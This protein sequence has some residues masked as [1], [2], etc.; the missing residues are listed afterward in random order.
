MNTHDIDFISDLHVDFWIKE[1][2]PSP[3]LVKQISAFISDVMKPK[4]NHILV[5]AG[6]TGHYFTQDSELLKQLNAIYEHVVIVTGN[7]DL[8]L[9]SHN[10]Q[11]KY[12]KHSYERVEEMKA[13]CKKEGIHYLEG[14]TVDIDGVI[15]GGTG[16]WYNLEGDARLAQWNEVM[17]DSNL[18]MSGADPVR[19]QYGY[20]AYHKASQWD[21]QAHYNKEVANLKSLVDKD[22]DV[23]VTHVLPVILPEDKMVS[24]Y[25]GDK[26]NIFYMSDNMETV[27]AINPDVI[28]FGHT[29]ESYDLDIDGQWFICNPLGYKGEFTGNSIQQITITKG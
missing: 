11:S 6:D 21:T 24:W 26:N 8:Y 14:D 13:F 3:K 27:Q 1:L 29:H 28:I 12:H 15:I 17:N 20:G 23:L 10:Q 9:V 16:M 4:G 18:I 2:S 22:V 7:H 5:L 25:R 19:F